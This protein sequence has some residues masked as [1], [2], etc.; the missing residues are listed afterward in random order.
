MVGWEGTPL[1]HETFSGL[2]VFGVPPIYG[3]HHMLLI[4]ANLGISCVLTDMEVGMIEGLISFTA[5]FSGE[6]GVFCR[7]YQV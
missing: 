2:T 7:A 4:F 6:E 5:M 1:Q 3:N